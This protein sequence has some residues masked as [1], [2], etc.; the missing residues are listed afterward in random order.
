MPT[1]SRLSIAPV[2]SLA[3]VHP[4]EV[5]LTRSG[6]VENRRFY[7]VDARG[8]LFSGIRHGPLVRIR[9]QWDPE[10]DWL[11]LSFPDGAVVQGEVALGKATRTNFWGRLV[12]GRLVEGPWAEALSAYAGKLL[13]LVRSDRP[14]DACDV[15]VATLVSDASVEELR[16]RAGRQE[17]VDAR[18][19]RI[20]FGINGCAPHE[21]DT[22][23]G[24]RIS[25]G[26]AVVRVIGPVPRCAVTTQDP[27]TGIPDLD[28]LRVIK[29]YRGQRDGRKLDFGVYADVEEE[30]RVRVGDPVEPE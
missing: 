13:R 3:L 26:A 4:D 17:P 18:R 16:R 11:S 6:V 12:A 10:R 5:L 23:V 30:G 28:T 27:S 14:G 20:L 2:K 29:G 8:R 9:S 1:V 7:L 21:E 15:H 22:W 19:F 25:I 24:R